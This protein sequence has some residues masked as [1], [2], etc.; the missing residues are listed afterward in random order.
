MGIVGCGALLAAGLGM[1]LNN[2]PGI[3]REGNAAHVEALRAIETQAFDL[4]LFAGLDGWTLG[5]ALDSEAIKGKVV[6]IGVVASDN[7]Q[8]TMALSGLARLERKNADKGLIVLAVHPENGWDVINEQVNSGRV[9]VQ[10]ARDVNGSFVEGVHADNYPDLFLIDRAG[11]L[12]YADIEN[13]SL[14]TAVSQLLSETVEVA[15]SNAQDQANGIEVVYEVAAKKAKGIPTA[16]YSNADWPM[17]NTGKLNA[18]NY[19]G[20]QLPVALGTEKWISKKKDLEGKVI[21]LDFWATWCGPC[22]RASPMLDKLQKEFEGKLEVL[23]IGGQSEDIGKVRNYA[24][25]HRVAYSHLFDKKQS[26]YRKLEIRAIPHTIVMSTDGVIRWQGN[27]LSPAFK[28]AVE[29]V[30]AQDPMFDD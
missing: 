23:A 7:P 26:I 4:N 27:P 10:V 25:S 15:I 18:K 19:Q 9:K 11:Q 21:V 30:I 29:Q 28:E 1:G 17:K 13:K 20:K 5:Q 16:K 8:S 6:L 3:L 2:G 24:R 12:R 22:K 14:K